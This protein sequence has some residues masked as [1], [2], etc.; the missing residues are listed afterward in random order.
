ME[1]PNLIKISSVVSQMKHMDMK[2]NNL[3][4]MCSYPI[5]Y[6]IIRKEELIKILKESKMETYFHHNVKHF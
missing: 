1:Y 6:K 4:C 2:R 3:S 5:K